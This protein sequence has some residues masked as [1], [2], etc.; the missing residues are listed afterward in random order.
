MRADERSVPPT[1][2]ASLLPP[3]TSPPH[4]HTAPHYRTV[5]GNFTDLCSCCC[6]HPP[7]PVNG[8]VA[9]DALCRLESKLLLLEVQHV[10]QLCGLALPRPL[11]PLD[12]LRGRTQHAASIH[13]PARDTHPSPAAVLCCFVEA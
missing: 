4:H 11:P 13:R 10:G 9:G 1:A 5:P 6:C 7:P 3:P 2:A 12:G 8:P